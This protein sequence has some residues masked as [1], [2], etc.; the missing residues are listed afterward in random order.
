MKKIINLFLI[1]ALFYLSG[2]SLGPDFQ[3]QDY[4]GPDAFR[5]DQVKT[6]SVVNLRTSDSNFIFDASI[7]KDQIYS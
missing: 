3:K 1:A 5:F 6:D 4:K 2:C 7:C